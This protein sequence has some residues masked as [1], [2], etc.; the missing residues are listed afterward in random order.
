MKNKDPETSLQH[1]AF[2]KPPSPSYATKNITR[3]DVL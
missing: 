2:E 3:S 1:L